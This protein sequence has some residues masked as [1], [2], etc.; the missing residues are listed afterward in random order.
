MELSNITN[1]VID[2]AD[3]DTD[4]KMDKYVDVILDLLNK[5][6]RVDAITTNNDDDLS[7]EYFSH[8]KFK[9]FEKPI[10]NLKDKEKELFHFL[11]PTALWVTNSKPLIKW[12]GEKEQPFCMEGR[13]SPKENNGISVLSFL[14]LRNIFDPSGL[15]IQTIIED[16]L[17]QW[18]NLGKK[19]MLI[20]IGNPPC[21]GM[22]TLVD[23][24]IMGLEGSGVSLVEKFNVDLV[25]PTAADI[26]EGNVQA[27]E[28]KEKGLQWLNERL[29]EP[30]GSE[31]EIIIN[32]DGTGENDI[33]ISPQSFLILQGERLFTD[34]LLNKF[35]YKILL[36]ISPL[37]ITR[38]LYEIDSDM[39]FTDTLVE[40]YL[41]KEGSE[42]NKY[43]KTVKDSKVLDIILD[44]ENQFTF[45]ISSKKR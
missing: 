26:I 20:G 34:E 36:D 24:I 39:K 22:E 7:E 8:P 23:K 21:G 25:L 28:K 13:K 10:L 19:R 3:R 29:L 16:I 15:A 18:K 44:G 31:D 6:Y 11:T 12:L 4:A 35:D 33:Y 42:Y 2:L 45:H 5:G 37:E 40:Q 38:R 41:E 32:V 43:L 9:I 1:F 30:F 27:Q 14:E 17:E